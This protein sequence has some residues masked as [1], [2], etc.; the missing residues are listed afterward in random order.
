M[1]TNKVI[2]AG[3]IGRF[4]NRCHSY[5]YGKHVEHKFGH[6]FYIPSQWEGS[7]L[8][9]NPAP[10]APP[11]FMKQGFVY[12]GGSINTDGFKQNKI[13]ID[14]YNKEM[15]DSVELIDPFTKSTYGKP[16]VA[17][18]SLVSDADWFFRDVRLSE[19]RSY[20]EFSDAVKNSEVYKELIKEKG[21]YDVAH[22]RRTDISRKNYVGGHSMVSKKS[23]HDAFKKFGTN[24][25]DVVWVSDEPSIG[26]NWKGAIPEING[27]KI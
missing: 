4:G 16:N 18:L 21:T 5:L 12:A 8:F 27:V 24:E 22:F 15:S 9:K 25:K 17:Y 19:L 14:E 20:F 2:C 13:K 3:W 6:K 7:V 23:Y 10:V 26:W 11:D 1:E